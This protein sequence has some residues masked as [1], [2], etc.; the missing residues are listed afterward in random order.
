MTFE[1]VCFCHHSSSTATEF[2]PLAFA[3]YR[4]LS[5]L[6]IASSNGSSNKCLDIPTLTVTFRPERGR[7]LFADL[8]DQQYRGLHPM[9]PSIQLK[10][11]LHPI[12]RK[13]HLF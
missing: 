1:A 10:I 3:L 5:A 7:S 6:F 4:A 12:L 8:I 11:H 9:K 2:L 13:D